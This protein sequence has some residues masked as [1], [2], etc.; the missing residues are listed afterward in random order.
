MNVGRPNENIMRLYIYMGINP[1]I[2][3]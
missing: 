1:I 3:P 2:N